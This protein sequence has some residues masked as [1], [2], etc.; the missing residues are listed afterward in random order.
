MLQFPFVALLWQ[1]NPLSNLPGGVLQS[2]PLSI[3][4]FSFQ[5]AFRSDSVNDLMDALLRAKL[6][7]ENNNKHL[8]CEQE[9]TD[10]YLLM[11]VADIFGAGVET[12]TTVLKWIVL[13]LLHYPEVVASPVLPMIS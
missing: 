3:L 10:D 5:E 1:A 9:L 13:Y 6:N 12:T 4:I 11:T 2:S 7:M 8:F